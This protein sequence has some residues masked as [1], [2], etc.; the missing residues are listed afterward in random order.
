MN[1]LVDFRET[2]LF[3]HIYLDGQDV[4][5][6]RGYRARRRETCPERAGLAQYPPDC[7][8]VLESVVT[9]PIPRERIV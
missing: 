2:F 9:D 4:W 3:V 7:S 8:Q 6:V 1:P 5:N